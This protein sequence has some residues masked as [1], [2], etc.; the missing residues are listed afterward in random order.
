MSLKSFPTIF[1]F[2]L[3]NSFSSKQSEIFQIIIH[4]NINF[5]FL[6]DIF[7]SVRTNEFTFLKL[8]GLL[9]ENKLVAFSELY[10]T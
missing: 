9:K 3:Y 2:L 8:V 5:V 4:S 10:L 1:V 6:S 7:Y